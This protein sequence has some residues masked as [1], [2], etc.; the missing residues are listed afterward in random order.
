MRAGQ[1][2]E[3][4]AYARRH[5]APWAGQ[6][7][8]ELQRA[9]ALLA[10]QAGTLCTPYRQLFEDQRVRA[11]GVQPARGARV[12]QTCPHG[13][14]CHGSLPC[15]TTAVAPSFQLSPP[16]RTLTARGP[17]GFPPAPVPQWAELIELFHQEL[18]RLNSLPPTSLLSIHLQAR[19]ASWLMVLSI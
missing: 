8:Q 4:I 19:L 7:M 18:Y 9:A 17:P 12:L 14:S 15:G 2:L 11:P 10:F 1:Q 13:L 16:L 5:L 3:A 6:Y